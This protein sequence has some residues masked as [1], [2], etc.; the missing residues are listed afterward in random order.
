MP[1]A[2]LALDDIT[3]RFGSTDALLAA[4]LHVHAGSVHA[5]LGENG[6][7]KTTLMR[8]AYGLLQPDRGS[9]RIDGEVTRH[10]R[11]RDAIRSGLGMVHQHFTIV[12]SMTVAENVA[13]GGSGVFHRHAV[14]DRVRTIGL[15]TG[16]TLDPHA[17]A[18]SLGVA[19]QQQLEIVKALS[20]D[21]RILI[22]DEPTA[23]LAPAEADSLLLRLRQ[24]AESGL[25]IVLITHKLREALAIA[26]E[27]TVLR[28]G[29]NVL[30]A[31]AATV[32][33]QELADAM[34]GSEWRDEQRASGAGR[35]SDAPSIARS[36]AVARA[37]DISVLDSHGVPRLRSASLEIHRGEIVGVAGVA[38]SGVYELLRAF[39]GRVPIA[40]GSLDRPIDIGFVPE[41]RHRDALVLDLS[42]TENVALRGAGARRGMIR[43]KSL[44]VST[45]ALLD[46]FDIRASSS[47]DPAAILSG[48]N[49]QKLVL[50]REISGG[51]TLLVVENPTRG[52]DLRASAAVH[53]RLRSSRDAGVAILL[54]SSDLDELLTLAD[55]VFVTHGGFI[56]ETAL[57]RTLIGQAML[58]A[59]S[60]D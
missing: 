37:T 21:A 17:L 27:V 20:H 26:D 55:R 42:L 43:W 11:A 22:L 59:S 10:A 5:V 25:S 34:L 6:A 51:P 57:D 38:G 33:E 35:H 29:R 32:S 16:I 24:L 18:G 52:L 39:A 50:A 44:E 49:Q 14:F 3:K 40:S 54:Y 23:V 12:P 58:G 47:E 9:I 53:E 15:Q 46:E 36:S 4:S 41:D 2:V 45:R 60:V 19:A 7:G 31:P 48:G 30:T 8:I 13:L 28:R 56:A 1:P